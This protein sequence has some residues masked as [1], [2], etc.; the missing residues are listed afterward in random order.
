MMLIYP[1]LDLVVITLVNLSG[2]K[3]ADLAWKIAALVQADQS[4]K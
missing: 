2:A 1:E 3:M 4:K